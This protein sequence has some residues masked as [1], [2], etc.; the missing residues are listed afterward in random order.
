MFNLVS[1]VILFV[2]VSN[3]AFANSCQD[4]LIVLISSTDYDIALL[5]SIGINDPC[6][7]A[8]FAH[9]ELGVREPNRLTR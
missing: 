7:M 2:F 6:A 5:T 4:T 8:S 1:T 9:D 3:T